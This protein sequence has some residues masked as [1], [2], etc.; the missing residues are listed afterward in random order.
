LSANI[1]N[2]VSQYHQSGV[3]AR[4]FDSYESLSARRPLNR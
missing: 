4:I 1:G 3:H 2:D